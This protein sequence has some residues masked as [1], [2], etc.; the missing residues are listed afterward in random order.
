VTS[1]VEI[2]LENARC[3]NLSHGAQRLQRLTLL[4]MMLEGST[5][6]PMKGSVV[7]DVGS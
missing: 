6:A 7:R 3:F 1:G 4:S 2:P 5:T